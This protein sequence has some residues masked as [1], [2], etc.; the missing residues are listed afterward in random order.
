MGV[1]T[2]QEIVQLVGAEPEYAAKLA[3]SLQKCAEANVRTSFQALK[4][5][6]SRVVPS[7]TKSSVPRYVRGNALNG[8]YLSVLGHLGVRQCKQIQMG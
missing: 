7:K 8:Q 2:D 6:G 3:V 5:I 1:Q 4:Y